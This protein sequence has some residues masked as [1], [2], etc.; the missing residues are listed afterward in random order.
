MTTATRENPNLW[1]HAHEPSKW[2]GRS[3][4]ILLTRTGARKQVNSSSHGEIFLLTSPFIELIEGERKHR[5]INPVTS[6][7]V[8]QY[9]IMPCLRALLIS[10]KL[11][12]LKAKSA[13]TATCKRFGIKAGT[14]R[15]SAL[16][17]RQA[18]YAL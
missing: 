16:E 3:K 11:Y 8:E 14:L 17:S 1:A 18:L 15:V 7:R 10:G 4:H 2:C 9:E 12:S 13:R 5:G 6:R